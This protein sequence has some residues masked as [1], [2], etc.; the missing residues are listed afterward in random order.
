MFKIISIIVYNLLILE[1][2]KKQL[3]F[4]LLLLTIS[5]NAQTPIFTPT[6]TVSGTGSVYS[7]AAEQVSNITDGN[8]ATKFLD[9]NYYDGLGF[10]VNLGGVS[11][12]ATSMDVTTAD[13]SPER[14]PKN[15]EV[16]GSNN[17]TQYTSI[18]TGVITCSTQRFYTRSY[19]FTNTQGYTYYKLVFK[20]QCNTIEQ[21][22]QLSEVQ[23]FENP[24]STTEFSSAA[25]DVQLYPNPGSGHFYVSQKGLQ[26]PID[27]VTVSDALG[28]VIKTLRFENTTTPEINMEG[29]AS[30]IYFVKIDADQ[31]SILKK[32]IV[33]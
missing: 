1:N 15:F 18:A 33:K 27:K 25:F 14:D 7:P 13:D 20:N 9:F 28:K 12:I 4:F 23:L 32:L 31:N 24:L 8:T 2:M 26:Q 3:P 30:G 16:F 11:K 22:I 10:I 6:M 21:M 17:G 5:A 19:T 29:V